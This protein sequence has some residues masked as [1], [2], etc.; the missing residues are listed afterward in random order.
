MRK[1]TVLLSLAALLAVS[2]VKN[3]LEFQRLSNVSVTPCKQNVVKS[4]RLSGEVDVAF[5]D[6][7][8]RITYCNFE[9]SCD[10]TTVDVAHTFEN[11]V[12]KITQQGS[13]NQA[14]CICYT[15]VSYTLEG[16]SQHEVNVI[17]INDEQVYC[18]NNGN[19]PSDCD[20]NIIFDEEAYFNAPEFRGTISNM[21]IEGDSLKFTVAAS[22][23]SGN[24]WIVQLITTRS[25][26]KTLPPQRTI[27]L[28]FENKE[29]C[30]AFIHRAFSFNIACLRREDTHQVQLNIAGHRILYEYG[31]DGGSQ[32]N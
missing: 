25:V 7:G 9:V 2:C 1:R 17:F 5:T 22:G 29:M 19:H 6:K 31:D 26:E 24:S 32:T 3:E 20:P 8:V 18:Y 10:F 30:K 23:C 21:K 16:F 11:G 14:N 15:D 27:Q 13:P 4:G 12:L 28:S